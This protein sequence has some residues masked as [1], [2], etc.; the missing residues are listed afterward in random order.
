MESRSEEVRIEGKDGPMGAHLALPAGQG[1]FPAVIVAMEAFGLNDHIRSV[2][3]RIANEGYVAIAPDFYHRSSDRVASYSDLPKAIG[4][5][6]ELSDE[7]ILADVDAVLGL[8]RRRSDVRG[9]RIGITGFCMGGRVSFLTACERDVA[10]SAPFYGGGIGGL[11]DHAERISA[12]MVLFFGEKDG[13]IPL[14][15]VDRV[16]ARLAELGK[17]AEVIVYPGAD[18]GFFCDE[19]PSYQAAAAADAWTRLLALFAKTLRK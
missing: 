15:E 18:H 16:Q 8:L 13:F 10:A 4:L 11:L 5:M 9:D 7:R 17:D 6:R 14:A 19:R 1:P 3:D 2:A 12:P